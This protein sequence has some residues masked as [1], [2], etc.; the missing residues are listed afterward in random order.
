MS[1]HSARDKKNQATS[2]KV[3]RCCVYK[4]RTVVLYFFFFHPNNKNKKFVKNDYFCRVN[5]KIDIILYKI[6]YAQLFLMR[7]SKV[8]DFHEEISILSTQVL[9]SVLSSI[10]NQ[11]I[12]QKNNVDSIVEL[13]VIVIIGT[14]RNEDRSKWISK[15]LI[16][17]GLFSPFIQILQK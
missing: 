6:T 3:R 15:V 10:I 1:A 7:K 17:V 14:Y 11:F 13:L 5:I 16:I 12:A 8:I 2:E 4:N 9:C